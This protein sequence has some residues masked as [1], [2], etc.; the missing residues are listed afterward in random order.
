MRRK[1]QAP[2][3]SFS[4]NER[5]NC[6][7]RTRNRGEPGNR[8]R[9][10]DPTLLGLLGARAGS[11]N[12]VLP[13]PVMT[14][15]RQSYLQHWASVHDMSVEEATEKFPREAGIAR[16]GRPEEIAE[17]MAFSFHRVRVG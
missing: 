16:Y 3:A 17:L 8:P 9:D 12:S 15:R 7:G 2:F 10:R 1:S 6:I 14:G 13:G 11:A 4:P 5:R